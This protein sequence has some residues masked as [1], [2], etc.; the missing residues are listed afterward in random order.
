[1]FQDK[2]RLDYLKDVANTEE[3]EESHTFVA[4]P[5]EEWCAIHNVV[6]AAFKN[7]SEICMSFPFTFFIC[8]MRVGTP[9]TTFIYFTYNNALITPFFLPFT[10]PNIFWKILQDI[11]E[12]VAYC[13]AW[14]YL[15]FKQSLIDV[16]NYS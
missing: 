12:K 8:E 11:L 9:N 13:S 7:I 1:M 3:S 14:N 6:P 16:R 5:E 4:K 2:H 15:F 10:F